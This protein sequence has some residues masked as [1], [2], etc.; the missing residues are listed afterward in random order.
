VRDSLDSKGRA[1]NE[2]PDSRERVLIEPTS[3]RKT[4]RQVKKGIDIPPSKLWPILVSVWKNYRDGN[5]KEPEVQRQKTQCE[6]QIKGRS[7]DL[8]LLL[9]YRA[10]TKWNLS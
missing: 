7:Q 9:S 3:S 5:G 2:M 10:F 4:G 6:I 8:T 1:L